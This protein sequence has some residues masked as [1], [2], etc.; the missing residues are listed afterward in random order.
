MGG[1]LISVF[2]CGVDRG[3]ESLSG[4]IKDYKI[5]ICSSARRSESNDRLTRNP[6]NVSDVGDMYTCG[7]L[8]KNPTQCVGLVKRVHRKVTCSWNDIAGKIARLEFSN[9]HSLTP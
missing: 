4:Q 1:E 9:N 8:S 6:D 5:A 3:F 7:L 2:G